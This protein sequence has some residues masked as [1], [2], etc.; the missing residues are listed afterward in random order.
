M[1]PDDFTLYAGGGYRIFRFEF[2]SNSPADSG[3]KLSLSAKN[4]EVYDASRVPPLAVPVISFRSKCKCLRQPNFTGTQV[5]R[6]SPLVRFKRSSRKGIPPRWTKK[7]DHRPLF[8]NHFD[9]IS[10]V[11]SEIRAVFSEIDKTHFIAT[12]L[13]IVRSV[14]TKRIRR[15]VYAPIGDYVSIYRVRTTPPAVRKTV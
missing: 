1:H 7:I 15:N 11:A 12:K 2:V 9:I 6:R 8:R 3:R 4:N 5:P 13:S 14:Y 10:L